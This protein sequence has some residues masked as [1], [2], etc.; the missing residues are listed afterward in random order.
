MNKHSYTF[1]DF[2]REYKRY[3]IP[4]VIAQLVLAALPII[5]ALVL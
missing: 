3:I 2:L 1:F 5:A 4:M